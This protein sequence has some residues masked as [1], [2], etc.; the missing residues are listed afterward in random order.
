[1]T[2]RTGIVCDFFISNLLENFKYNNKHNAWFTPSLHI[3]SIKRIWNF[4]VCDKFACFNIF[5]YIWVRFCGLLFHYM[6]TSKLDIFVNMRR[7]LF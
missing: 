6:Q 5:Y 3:I 1:L 7:S 2:K 4:A